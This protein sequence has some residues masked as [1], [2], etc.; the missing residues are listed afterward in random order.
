MNKKILAAAMTGLLGLQLFAGAGAFAEE[1]RHDFRGQQT[2]QNGNGTYNI[3]RGSMSNQNR[4]RDFARAEGNRTVDFARRD[5]NGNRGGDYRDH[6][7]DEQGSGNNWI[8]PAIISTLP[9][10]LGAISGA[11]NQAYAYPAYQ[12]YPAYSTYPAYQPAPV[13]TTPAYPAYGN[14]NYCPPGTTYQYP[15]YNPGY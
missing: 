6:Q 2:F 9:S 8:L 15:T 1:N 14:N 4:G 11:N 10:I 12:A 13:Y 3:S 5:G 7:R